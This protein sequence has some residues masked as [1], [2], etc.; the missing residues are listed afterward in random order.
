MAGVHLSAIQGAGHGPY[1]DNWPVDGSAVCAHIH[2]T[3]YLLAS[4]RACW[5]FH[6]ILCFL[7][8]NTSNSA[9]LREASD[10]TE[11]CS[12]RENL[13]FV[14]GIFLCSLF[15]QGLRHLQVA[16]EESEHV[17]SL[18]NISYKNKQIHKHKHHTHLTPL[19][20]SVKFLNYQEQQ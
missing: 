12:D 2:S 6:Q 8:I 10:Y 18:Y 3:C 20:K 5:R 17:F 9:V 19:T 7:S 1:A 13:C 4:P 14:M 15:L 11:V 16:T